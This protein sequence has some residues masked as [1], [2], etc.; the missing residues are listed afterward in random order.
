M[1]KRK[2]P[3]ASNYV[4]RD[5]C[6]TEKPYGVSMTI[7]DQAMSLDVMLQRFSSGL[8]VTGRN[9]GF[10]DGDDYVPD[11]NSLDLVDIQEMKDEAD[12]VVKRWNKS[13]IRKVDKQ[14][15]LDKF[16]LDTADEDHLRSLEKVRGRTAANPD[17]KAKLPAEGD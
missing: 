7:P 2:F 15:A 9:D 5:F 17:S 11:Y 4:S 3:W 16:D 8:P 10:Y 14:A 1:K 6:Q 13:K 12:F